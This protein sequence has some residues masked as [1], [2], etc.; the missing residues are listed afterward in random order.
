MAT[1]FESLHPQ[2]ITDADGAR[3]A[4]VLSLAEYEALLEDIADLAAVAERQDEDC[5]SFEE[6]KAGLRADGLL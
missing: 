4:V 3:V 6:L 1:V 2:F 5:V